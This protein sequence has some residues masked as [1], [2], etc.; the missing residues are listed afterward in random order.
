[1]SFA[2]AFRDHP[3]HGRRAS[4]VWSPRVR[5]PR[6][7]NGVSRA[8]TRFA[9]TMTVPRPLVDRWL[10]AGHWAEFSR[11][12]DL[13]P[14]WSTGAAGLRCDNCGAS[15]ASLCDM[16]CPDRRLTS[17]PE[18]LAVRVPCESHDDHRGGAADHD[19]LHCVDG[20]VTV[21]WATNE[22][23]PLQVVG[24]RYRLR[25]SRPHQFR[26]SDGSYHD[27]TPDVD[28]ICLPGRWA[29]GGSIEAIP[30]F[31]GPTRGSDPWSVRVGPR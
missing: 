15:E 20:L 23:G 30:G 19:H 14:D 11:G 24:H 27:V 25:R 13:P 17:V 4:D 29:R 31:T 21:A 26:L 18:R 22:F 16:S 1:M 6:P 7:G 9:P 5:E 12:G 2:I 8:G 28:P 3:D 10:A